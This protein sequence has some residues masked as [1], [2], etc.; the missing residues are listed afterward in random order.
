MLFDV[1]IRVPEPSTCGPIVVPTDL[2]C[3]HYRNICVIDAKRISPTLASFG[4]LFYCSETS[5]HRT[6]LDAGRESSAAAPGGEGTGRNKAVGPCPM[7][8]QVEIFPL[9]SSLLQFPRAW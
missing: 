8:P 2:S 1:R 9:I 5:Y 4:T 3:W 7:F 6:K